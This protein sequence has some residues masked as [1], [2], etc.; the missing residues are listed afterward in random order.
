ML[1]P[2]PPVPLPHICLGEFSETRQERVP[3]DHV[4]E[5]FEPVEEGVE[6]SVQDMERMKNDEEVY[7][8]SDL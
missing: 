5:K 2:V 7:K 1:V 4:S 6:V 8:I 3:G